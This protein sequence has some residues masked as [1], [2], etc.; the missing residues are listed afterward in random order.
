[1]EPWYTSYKNEKENFFAQAFK[2]IIQKSH[3]KDLQNSTMMIDRL[4]GL[5][6]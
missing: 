5:V 4:M 1:M 6:T 2:T 3:L